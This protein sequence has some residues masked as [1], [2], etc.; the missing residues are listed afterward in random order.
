MLVAINETT[1][2][3]AD[4]S[5]ARVPS[6]LFP[7]LSQI[8][9]HMISR[10][11][12]GSFSSS[13]PFMTYPWVWRWVLHR[14]DPHLLE[15]ICFQKPTW[16]CALSTGAD[17]NPVLYQCCCSSQLIVLHH[18]AG[19][20]AVWRGIIIFSVFSS[21]WLTHFS[22]FLCFPGEGFLYFEIL[23]SLSSNTRVLPQTF[24]LPGI[25]HW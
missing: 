4:N 12:V 8:V 17:V 14:I 6:F 3:C 25:T 15:E 13:S 19:A 9:L 1:I 16:W 5:V 24:S 10:S 20:K 18:L 23:P 22:C 21:S 11:T 7:H 2:H